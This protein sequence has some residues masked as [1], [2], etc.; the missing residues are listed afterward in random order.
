LSEKIGHDWEYRDGV[1]LFGSQRSDDTEWSQF[2]DFA[3]MSNLSIF[4]QVVWALAIVVAGFAIALVQFVWI[5]RRVLSPIDQAAKF[6]KA[7]V[8][9]SLGDFLCL[10]LAIQIPLAAVHRFWDED[11]MEAYWVFTIITWLVAPVIWFAGA[12]A[13][14]KAQVSTSSHRFVFLGL[15]MPLVYYGLIPFTVLGLSFLSPLVGHTDLPFRWLLSIW[16][17]LGILF[18]LSGRY[19]R[20]MLQHVERDEEPISDRQHDN[21]IFRAAMLDSSAAARLDVTPSSR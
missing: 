1:L 17:V 21:K 14:S 15:V 5:A 18:Y 11:T 19:V 9:F 8:R 7:A 6:R 20:W 4:L 12:R 10:F 16:F 13:L 3:S 2:R